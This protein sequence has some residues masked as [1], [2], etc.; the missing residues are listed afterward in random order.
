MLVARQTQD[1]DTELM[2]HDGKVTRHLGDW[3]SVIGVLALLI[4][5]AGFQ[6]SCLMSWIV[7][8][9]WFVVTIV[10]NISEYPGWRM[11]LLRIALPVIVLLLAT[12]N[13]VFQF[14]VSEANSAQ[15]ITACEDYY[16][17]SGQYPDTLEQLVPL[18]LPSIPPAKYCLDGSFSYVKANEES[19]I[20]LWREPPPFFLKVYHFET[21][22]WGGAG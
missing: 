5:D 18:Y 10:W 21:R 22:R 9:I 14:R 11:S 17:V 8:P 4:W 15:I 6:G 13:A 2:T 16:A 20:L 7:C 3:A 12:S 1:E 19:H